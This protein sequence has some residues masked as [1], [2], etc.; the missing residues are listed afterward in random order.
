VE[1]LQVELVAYVSVIV[2][3][4]GV[5]GAVLYY[6]FTLRN[7]ARMR[8]TDLIMRLF[9]TYI[10]KEFQEAEAKVLSL[11][12]EDYAEFKEQYGP[13]PSEESMHI[14]IRTVGSF[15]EAIGILLKRNLIQMDLVTDLFAIGLRWE[16]L[17][18]IFRGLR[19]QFDEP[20]LGIYFEY[21]ADAEKKVRK[22][23]VKS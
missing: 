23:V 10:G 21:L 13:Y 6:V 18:P 19:E 2:A 16:K 12:V 11:N 7:Q 1:D 15:F 5:T 17:W 4:F 22:S 20:G 9:T 14:A 3:A 8:K